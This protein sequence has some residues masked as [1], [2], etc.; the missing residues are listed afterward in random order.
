MNDQNI[1]NII[2]KIYS[3][4]LK[5]T[6]RETQIITQETCH[7]TPQETVPKGFFWF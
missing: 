5:V 1:L 2:L 4:I 7:T 6:G 3:I